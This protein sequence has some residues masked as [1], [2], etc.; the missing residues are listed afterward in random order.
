MAASA[1]SSAA[2]SARWV[3]IRTGASAPACSTCRIRLMEMPAS[4]S[5]AATLASTPGASA[6]RKRR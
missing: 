2:R 5:A 1:R 4:P 3:T 6:S